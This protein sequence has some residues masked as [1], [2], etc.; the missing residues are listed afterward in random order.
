MSE[1]RL[2]YEY[3]GNKFWQHTS[4][5]FVHTLKFKNVCLIKS[6]ILPGMW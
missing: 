4:V 5:L 6:H 1:V 3:D 2:L